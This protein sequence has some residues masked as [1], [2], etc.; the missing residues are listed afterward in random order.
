MHINYCWYRNTFNFI[1][2]FCLDTL[3][4]QNLIIMLRLKNAQEMYLLLPQAHAQ[5]VI[6]RD[7][8]VIVSTK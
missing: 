4:S 5:G 2:K 3:Y 1:V 6:S 7:I 8:I